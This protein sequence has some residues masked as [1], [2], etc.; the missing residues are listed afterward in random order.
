[1]PPWVAAWL[2]KVRPD[3]VVTHWPFDT[4]PNHHVTS[5]L[6]WQC[7]LR[8]RTWNLYFFEVMTD[9][10]TKGFRPELYLDIANV[11]EIK[12]K[13]CFR[14]ESQRPEGFWGVHEEMQRRRGAECGVDYAVA[15]VLVERRRNARLLPVNF[16]SKKK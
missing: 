3:I 13:A 9:Q 7:Y 6:V 10:Q 8:E 14:H 4:H 15:Y 2:K 16:L 1:M 12:K 11:R 5:S